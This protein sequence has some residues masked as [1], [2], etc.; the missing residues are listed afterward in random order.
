MNRLAP[1]VKRIATQIERERRD[2]QHKFRDLPYDR[3]TRQA[4]CELA[5]SLRPKTDNLVVLGIGGSALGTTALH[6]A[7]NHAHYNLLSRRQRGGPRLFVMDNI[8]PD[9][10]AA[11]L[12]VINKELPRTLFNVI[13]KSGETV[14][15]AAQFMIIRRLLRKR[16][17]VT[18]ARKQIVVTTDSRSGTMRDITATEGYASKACYGSC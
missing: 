11:T 18:Q 10:F 9:G 7:L 4:A 3:L 12:D 13:S 17:G 14:E 8:D 6:T 2:G 5:K 1:R 15:T 16:L